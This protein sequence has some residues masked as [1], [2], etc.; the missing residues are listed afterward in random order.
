MQSP[1][2]RQPDQFIE[3][4]EEDIGSHLHSAWQP[5]S[6]TAGGRAIGDL[7]S[8]DLLDGSWLVSSE[9]VR[10]GQAATYDVLPAGET[11]RYWANGILL[12]STLK[13]P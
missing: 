13:F 7:K 5:R 12:G 2:N 11:G 3:V 8:G 10:Y 1:A 4:H 9:A 6:T